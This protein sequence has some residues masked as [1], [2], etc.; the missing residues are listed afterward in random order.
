M[1]RS[2]AQNSHVGAL[3]SI[4][5]IFSFFSVL[6]YRSLQYY[7]TTNQHDA[8]TTWHSYA[9]IPLF[10][11]PFMLTNFYYITITGNPEVAATIQNL[12][13]ACMY[14]RRPFCSSR[15]AS[16]RSTS[17]RFPLPS[18]RAFSLRPFR[19]ILAFAWTCSP[20]RL[21]HT[22]TYTHI[23]THTHTH[24]HSLSLSLYLSLPILS[25]TTLH[26]RSNYL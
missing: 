21:C 1:R 14:I 7:R 25:W 5:L 9:L 6:S 17:S 10:S 15:R 8:A 16:H 4:L 24:T 22:H 13:T 23:H 20:R 26:T 11:H 12:D 18:P 19:L 2:H 3:V